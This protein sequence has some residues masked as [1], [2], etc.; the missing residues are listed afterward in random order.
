MNQT[1]WSVELD[2]LLTSSEVAVIWTLATLRNRSLY[3]PCWTMPSTLTVNWVSL[4]TWTGSRPESC[5]GEMANWKPQKNHFCILVKI[6]WTS[7]KH[8]ISPFSMSHYCKVYWISWYSE[9]L[10]VGSLKRLEKEPRVGERSV[11]QPPNRLTQE[12]NLL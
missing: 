12:I 8:I 1:F 9:Y 6:K 10:N 4:W 5:W 3:R 11:Y 7:R 2:V